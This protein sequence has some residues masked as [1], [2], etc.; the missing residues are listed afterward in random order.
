M[1][2]MHM[3]EYNLFIHVGWEKPEHK[4]CT[5]EPASGDKKTAVIH[6]TGYCGAV[7][8]ACLGMG[9]PILSITDNQVYHEY[10]SMTVGN[11]LLE[12]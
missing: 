8:K 10:T 4:P 12:A 6:T 1:H 7:E 5:M 2:M 11:M 9:I 3:F